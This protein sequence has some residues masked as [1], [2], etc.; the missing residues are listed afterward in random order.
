D[1][2]VERH[3]AV[4]VADGAIEHSDLRIGPGDR[5]ETSGSRRR[6]LERIDGGV[7][8]RLAKCLRGVAGIRTDID[9]RLHRAAGTQAGTPRLE[10]AGIVEVAFDW[11][12]IGRNVRLHCPTV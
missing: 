7:G 8:I 11:W 3:D 1:D 9:N 12:Q 6:R 4:R 5:L 10:G 2:F